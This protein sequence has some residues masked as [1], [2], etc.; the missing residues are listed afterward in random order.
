MSAH[1]VVLLLETDPQRGLSS[2]EANRRLERYGRNVLPAAGGGGVLRRILRQF[3]NPLIYVLI[4][5]SVVTVFLGEYVDSAVIF[6]VVLINAAI[7]YVQESRAEAALDS[8]R[9][10]VRTEARVVRDGELRSISSDELVPGD[11]VRLEAGDKVP[12]DL[13]LVRLAELRIDE[14]AL[15]GESVPVDKLEAELPVGTPVA[16]RRNMVWSGTLVAAGSG[17][18][19][20]VATGAETEL[21]QIHRLVGA[22]EVLATPLTRKLARFSKVLTV[23]ILVLAAVT[24]AV[25][26]LRGQD[27]V[28]TFTATVA[29]AVGAIP[30]G[31][32]AAVTITLAIGVTRMARRRAVI[33]RLPAIETL[34]STTLVCSDKTG[35]LTENQM[36]VRALWTPDGGY[37]VTGSG[38]RPEGEIRDDG[39]SSEA[40]RWS[41]LAGA[42]CNDARIREQDGE[43]T[44]AGDPT[45]GA[46][47][48]V[49]AKAGIDQDELAAD[50]PRRDTIPFDS[51]RQYMAT[52]HDE[53][54]TRRTVVLAK[55]SVER[56]VSMCRAEMGADG[57]LRP[58]RAEAALHAAEE[59]AGRGLRVLA[60]AVRPPDGA[61][62]GFDDSSLPGALVLT[63]LQAMLDPP[64][65]AAAPAV[66]ACHTAGIGV[67]MIT[68]D[69]AATA[70]AI[71]R[72]LGLL[73]E[74]RRDRV[75]TGTDLDGLPA[76]G[77]SDA[78]ENAAVF[79]RV[80]PAQKL[81]LVE[82]LQRRGHVVAVTGDGV[83]D[84]PALRQANIGIAMAR[85]GTEVAKEA[86]DMVL[87]DDDFA[88]IEAAVEEGRGVF[89]NITKFIVWTLP[90]NLGEGLVVLVAIVLG[91]TLPLLPTQ[92]L[93]INMTTA[94]LLGLMLAFEP[95]EAGIMRRPPRDPGRPLLT[96][97]LM[98]RIV[99]VATLLVAGAWWIFQW[100]QSNGADVAQARTAA[101]NLFV[102]VEMFYLFSC[103]SLTRSAWRIG[104]FTNRW[105]LLG[106][107]AQALCQLAIT[108]LP[109]MNDIFGTAP[110][111]VEVWLRIL[112][113]GVVAAL[114]VA[115]DKRLRRNLG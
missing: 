15:T 51:T 114:V 37:E 69:H 89:D 112:A 41:L 96:A 48:V 40:L 68:G 60:T 44:L 90:T 55:G 81:R 54:V 21:G 109:P 27:A 34:G 110:I 82:T 30:E 102:V 80:S 50:Y 87:T 92:I 115:V 67:K 57:A 105:L 18:G 17:T 7:G 32:P 106:V 26:L 29:L 58:V 35:T 20:A 104:F 9:S 113:V 101:L 45:E 11:L 93:W 95:K 100:E 79:A 56:I 5:A 13:R 71:A 23:I 108:Y 28:E 103:R 99:L 66:R 98:I 42:G 2:T 75:V 43:W 72:Q 65:S 46:M 76:E 31:L 8:L 36:T 12:V 14:S 73:D 16:D 85:S 88:T 78:V 97:A 86:A 84:A 1:E 61:D 53:R 3:H 25:G 6:A 64:R 38:Y 10:M 19:I 59:L 83:N 70:G 62:D 47:L 91:A 52:L 22:A 111:G 33:R 24:F 77:F 39:R 49:A 63:G 4:A 107:A 74:D 94:V